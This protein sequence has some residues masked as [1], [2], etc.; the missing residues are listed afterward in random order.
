VAGGGG[1]GRSGGSV[2]MYGNVDFVDS[3][4]SD[5]R[6]RNFVIIVRLILRKEVHERVVGLAQLASINYEVARQGTAGDIK[7]LTAWGVEKLY[8]S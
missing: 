8:P 7:R 5:Q 6:G 4:K 1:S 3:R 2:V